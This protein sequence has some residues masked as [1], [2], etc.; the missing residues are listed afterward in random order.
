MLGDRGT[1]N[2]LYGSLQV[3]GRPDETL[4]K[5][6]K[7]II[8]SAKEYTPP[9]KI[10]T[11]DAKEFAKYAKKEIDYYKSVYPGFKADIEIR[12]DIVSSAMV[13]SEKFLIYK[14][15]AFPEHR[16][17]AL[18]N[19]EIGTHIL[20]YF[21]GMSQPF[22]QLHT[23]LCGYDE[24]QEGLAVLSEYLCGGLTVNRMKI[25]AGRVL[26]VDAMVEGADFI[27]TFRYLKK[28]ADLAEKS[29]FSVTARVFRG[30][31]LTKD[32]VYLRGFLEVLNFIREK[33]RIKPLYAGKIAARHIPMIH[34]LMLRKVLHEPPL[35]P[36]YLDTNEAKK[37]I[38]D[39]KKGENILDILK[40][41]L[42]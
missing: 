3:Y 13:S 11:L 37:R 10:K 5:S 23:G 1:K 24:M 12:E 42:Q 22:K 6:A 33:G 27:E 9:K 8:E 16:I 39:L 28:N 29:A 35:Y 20:T 34:E 14:W 21:N 19:H 32:A 2:F 38:E 36:R 40:K 31:G 4:L 17:E 26:A 25:L 41:E 15:A 18:L 30:G 7:E